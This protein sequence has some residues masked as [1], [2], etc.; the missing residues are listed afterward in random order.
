MDHDDTDNQK[1]TGNQQQVKHSQQVK[2]TGEHGKRWQ[3]NFRN[4]SP[5]NGLK[6]KHRQRVKTEAQVTGQSNN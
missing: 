5:D 3:V 4:L 1:S 2:L 6:L